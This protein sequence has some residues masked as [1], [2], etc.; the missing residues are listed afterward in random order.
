M[1]LELVEIPFKTSALSPAFFSFT[2]RNVM[3]FSSCHLAR[4][5]SVVIFKY[6]FSILNVDYN[7]APLPSPLPY[8][9]V[10]YRINIAYYKYDATTLWSKFRRDWTT[11]TLTQ[12]I[13]WHI[14]DQGLIHR[15]YFCQVQV[16]QKSDSS[17][18]AIAVRENDDI[19]GIDW[20]DPRYPPKTFRRLFGLG[21]VI[22]RHFT[23]KE[24]LVSFFWL[25]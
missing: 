18:C 23:G 16:Q 17:I 10:R 25:H 14:S 3:F 7:P 11:W 4:R 5:Y 8:H 1:S 24:F 6:S 21:G 13:G 12:S 9:M 19:L 22:Q 15:T 20:Y 2:D